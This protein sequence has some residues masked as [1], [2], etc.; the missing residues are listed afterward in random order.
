MVN[1][2]GRGTTGIVAGVVAGNLPGF[3][4]RLTMRVLRL[5]LAACS[6]A[7]PL[8]AAAAVQLPNLF[9]D[10]AVLQRD[11]PVRIWGWGRAAENV[12]VRF[13]GQTVTTQTDP[14]GYWEAW[15]KPEPA[16]GPYTLTVSGDSTPIPLERKDILLGDVWLASGQSNMEF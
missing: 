7:L 6:L 8:T 9:S 10:H 13:H 14:I 11:R 15:L 2:R 4:W 12:T 16:G 1:L 5:L 3:C